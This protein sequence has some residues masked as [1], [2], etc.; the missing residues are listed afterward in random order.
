MLFVSFVV[1]GFYAF[2]DKLKG[3]DP[4]LCEVGSVQPLYRM[5]V[6]GLL[7]AAASVLNCARITAE[8]VI[9]THL[10]VD[11]QHRVQ[12]HLRREHPILINY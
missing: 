12:S 4:A 9:A 11:F 5:T 1:R 10:R 3:G 8:W 6:I 2:C 7:R